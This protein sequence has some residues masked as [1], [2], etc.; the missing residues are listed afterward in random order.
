MAA[1]IKVSEVSFE[2]H[3]EVIRAGHFR[4]AHA[5]LKNKAGLPCIVMAH[6]LGGTRAAGL[7]P[8]AEAFAAAGF[9]VVCFDYRYFG[10]SGGE[11]RQQIDIH[12]QLQDW[13]VAI[14]YARE[15]SGI[16]GS[17]IGLWGSS[18]SGGHVVAAAV[19][20]GK[21]AAI[22]SQGAMMD[23]L[24]A[25]LNIVKYAGVVYAAKVMAIAVRD[26]MRSTMG[27]PRILLPIVAAAGVPAF[28]SSPGCVEGYGAITGPEWRNEGTATWL[29]GLAAYR[30]VNMAERLPCKALF[31]ICT[32]DNVV[33]PSAVEKAAVNAGDKA[34]VKRYPIGHFD[35]YV[36]KGFANASADQVEFF[37]RVMKPV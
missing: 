14:D 12:A 10:T 36:G 20:D 1:G 3:G 13:A 28:V 24:A 17:R 35:I 33:P 37:S 6:G 29:I 19:A 30:P 4:A 18:F 8:F 5:A 31:C 25:A 2:S 7:T 26:A 9:E 27:A 11:P 15:L 16:D 21:V 23:G 34:E 22:S 32:E